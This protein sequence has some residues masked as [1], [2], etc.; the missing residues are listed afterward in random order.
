M[1]ASKADII[2]K[3][4]QQITAMGGIKP[5]APKSNLNSGLSFLKNHLPFGQFP[6]GAMH[7]FSCSNYENSASTAGFISAIIASCINSDGI[8]FWIS[9][10]NTPFAPALQQFNIAPDKSIC[11]YTKNEKEI[12]WALEETLRCDKVAAVVSFVK[13]LH[14]TQARRLQLAVEKSNV[15]GFVINSS[16]TQSYATTCVSRWQVK[17]LPSQCNNGIPGLG[18]PRWDVELQKIRNGKPG[19]WQVEWQADHFKNIVPEIYYNAQQKVS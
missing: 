10:T 16:H 4:Q 19:H 2:A 3:L 18:H 1:N 8:V 6:L 13:N 9:N 12:L 7:E 15:T 17:A 11:I 5:A 14:F